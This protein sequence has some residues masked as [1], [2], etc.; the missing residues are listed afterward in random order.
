M[1]LE[2]LIEFNVDKF[3]VYIGSVAPQ[4][5]VICQTEP[6]AKVRATALRC[7]LSLL[8][9]PYHNIHAVKGNVVKGLQKVTD[10]NKKAIRLLAAKVR[11]KYITVS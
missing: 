9:L 5:I 8:Q 3:A 2:T 11:N 1:L 4:L 10:D 6:Q 7:L